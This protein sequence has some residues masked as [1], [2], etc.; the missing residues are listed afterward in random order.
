MV[1]SSPHRP[2]RTEPVAITDLLPMT[3]RDLARTLAGGHPI[4]ATDLDDTE[5]CGVGLGLPSFVDTIAWKTFRKAF[6]RDPATGH[7]RGW[8]IRVHQTGV[9]GDY[10]SK[11]HDG[12][13]ATWGHFRV[14]P[15]DLDR[16]PSGTA[17]QGLLI[18]YGLGCNRRHSMLG[19]MRDPLVAVNA[20][21]SDL[22]L[23]WSYLQLG[24]RRIP[25]PS[26][27]VLRRD[28]PLSH[29]AHPPTSA[30]AS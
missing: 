1:I 5:Y 7:L 19:L 26:Y 28:C 21:S 10:A 4:N 23:G 25:T 13:P 8:N 11:T 29:V 9:D 27:F 24:S 18:D 17:G 12:V 3:R 6:H 15:N 22:L 20:G 2:I 14:V 16:Y 30:S